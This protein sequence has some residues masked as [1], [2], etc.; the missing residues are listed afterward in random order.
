MHAVGRANSPTGRMNP[1]FDPI[2]APTG[3][4]DPYR[5]VVEEFW[6]LSDHE[7]MVEGSIAVPSVEYRP[8]RSLHRDPGR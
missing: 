8:S 2:F 7:E 6:A 4:R 5:Y 1:D 3:S